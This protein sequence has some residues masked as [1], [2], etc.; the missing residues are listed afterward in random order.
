[1]AMSC[2]ANTQTDFHGHKHTYS[3]GALT[4]TGAASAI[5]TTPA[6]KLPHVMPP[7]HPILPSYSDSR[8]ILQDNTGQPLGLN[9]P[10]CVLPFLSLGVMEGLIAPAD[11]LHERHKATAQLEASY[12]FPRCRPMHAWFYMTSA[13]AC[14]YDGCSARGYWWRV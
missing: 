3:V 7:F 11:Y 2:K 4:T 12:T 6:V 14:T 13:Y 9:A 1:M 8:L 5:L 10:R